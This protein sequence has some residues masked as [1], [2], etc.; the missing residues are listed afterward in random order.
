M[1][2]KKISVHY[3]HFSFENRVLFTVLTDFS[4][5]NLETTTSTFLSKFSYEIYLSRQTVTIHR[6]A[7]KEKQPLEVLYKKGALSK[8]KRS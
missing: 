1:E 5:E 4:F 3:F 8:K 6:I 2:R 7:G